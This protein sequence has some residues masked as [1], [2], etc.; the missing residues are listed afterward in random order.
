MTGRLRTLGRRLRRQAADHDGF[1][2]VELVI[3]MGILAI[4]VAA[5]LTTF[6]ASAVS[7]RRAGQKGTATTLADTQMEWYRRLSFTAVRIDGTLI[8][9]T[10]SYVDAHSED[11]TIPASTNQALAGS[12]GDTSCPSGDAEPAACLPVQPVTGPDGHA[13]RIDTYV[14]YVNNDSTLSVR[15]PAPG[16]ILKR[17]TVVV[18]DGTTGTILARESSAFQGS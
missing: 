5:L 13:Y 15:T 9:S 12:N 11:S 18:R 6:A 3:A 10:G 16:L 7:L 8:P 4:A 17:V 1:G 14:N 2:M